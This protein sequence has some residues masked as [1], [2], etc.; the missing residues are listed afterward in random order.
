MSAAGE[1]AASAEEASFM[2]SDLA[3]TREALDMRTAKPWSRV[4][5]GSRE[6]APVRK[7]TST[8]RRT[9]AQEEVC[10][11]ERGSTGSRWEREKGS[12]DNTFSK[13]TPV[14]GGAGYS[15]V[16]F[17]LTQLERGPGS[18]V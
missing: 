13:T 7:N 1:G 11:R 18:Q 8:S 12:R 15:V 14:I 3:M 5:V 17:R 10:S 6:G 4:E 16:S 2:L 9:W